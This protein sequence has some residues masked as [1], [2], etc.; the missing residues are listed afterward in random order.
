MWFCNTCVQREWCVFLAI[1][2]KYL[3][4][5]SMNLLFARLNMILC[6]LCFCFS[7]CYYI[8]LYSIWWDHTLTTVI[9]VFFFDNKVKCKYKSNVIF[10][11]IFLYQYSNF[12]LTVFYTLNFLF[13][14]IILLICIIGAVWVFI[15]FQNFHYFYLCIS[16]GHLDLCY[17]VCFWL[18]SL[19]FWQHHWIFIF[20]FVWCH[21]IW[22]YNCFKF[23]S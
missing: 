22:F 17:Y 19:F 2:L 6:I 14:V 21:F 23:E 5:W 11:N 18:C 10:L 12:V 3:Y 9:L 20:C 7:Y 4:D 8:G 15:Q 13:G 16:I 1:K